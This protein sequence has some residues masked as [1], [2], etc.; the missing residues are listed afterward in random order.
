MGSGGA[1]PLLGQAMVRHRLLLAAVLAGPIGAAALAT[2]ARAS[3]MAVVASADAR[4][5]LFS[6]L[7]APFAEELVFRAGVQTSLERWPTMRRRFA[8]G[9]DG[10]NLATSLL[11]AGSHAFNRSP[12]LAA[13]VVLPSLLLGCVKQRYGSLAPCIVLHSWF[14]ACFA[15]MLAR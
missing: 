11:F 15:A 12:W 6:L 3:G 9:I 7:I 4:S 8:A 1:I 5:L 2:L 13:A 14:N 10:A